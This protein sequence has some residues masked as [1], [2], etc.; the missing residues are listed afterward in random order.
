[1][2]Q[3]FV[4]DTSIANGLMT[5]SQTGGYTCNFGLLRLLLRHGQTGEHISYMAHERYRPKA[6]STVGRA[7][8][9][10][11]FFEG[12]VLEV[13]RPFEPL[14]SLRAPEAVRIHCFHKNRMTRMAGVRAKITLIR[15]PTLGHKERTR[16][17]HQKDM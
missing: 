10:T 3:A 5:N 17:A 9:G 11:E 12:T 13:C 6:P 1:M 14:A 8:K 7:S 16:N 2:A 15:S 4:T